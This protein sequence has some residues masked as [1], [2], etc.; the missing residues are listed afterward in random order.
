M[1][2]RVNAGGGCEA[3]VTAEA[4]Y[5][6]VRFRECSK[7]LYGKRFP[8]RLKGGAI[9]KRYPRPATLYGSEVWCLSENEMAFFCE[10]KRNTW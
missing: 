9:Y 2:N 6:W 4:R 8:L 7:L 5:G 3:A 10:G 1:D